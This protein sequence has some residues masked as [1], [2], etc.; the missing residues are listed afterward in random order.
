MEQRNKTYYL[1]L[2]IG[3]DSVGYAA[4]N[5]NYE[6]IKF[7]G[8][9]VWGVTTFE[10][11]M[12][13][14]ERRI[15]R[16]SRRRLD[17]RQQRVQ[18]V[19]EI[20]QREICKIDPLFFIRRKESA[21]FAEDS[22]YGVSLL[23][24]KKADQ[25]YHFRYPT[26]HH[27]I[28]D[29]MTS[30]EPHDV[31][32]VYLAC[33]WLVVNRGHFL[34]NASA[35][36]VGDFREPYQSFLECFTNS[37]DCCTPWPESISADVIQRI[38]Q[39]DVNI[40]RKK[41]MFKAE[42]FGGKSPAKKPDADFPFSRDSIVTLLSGGK[43][44]PK[45][46]F[47]ND[48]YKE[49]DSVSLG[50]E[51]EKF[52]S[53]LGELDEDAE[54]LRAMRAM[55]DCALL[56]ITLRGKSS[57]SE[58]MVA[59][60]D[61]HHNDL[62]FLKYFIRKYQKESYN[63]I[64]RN[65]AEGNYVAYSG[66]VKNCTEANKVKK[67]KKEAFC[68]YIR[69]I[70]SKIT[71]EEADSEKYEDMLQRLSLY[72]FL[73][74]QKNSDNRVIPHQLY[75]YELNELLRHAGAYL[76]M[77]R[78]TDEDGI[79]NEEKI[80]SIFSFRI[81]YYVG[82]LNKQSPNAW[83]ERKSGKIYP[84]NFEKMVDQDASEQ[85]FIKRMTNICTYLPG[86]DVLPYCSMLYNRFMVLNEL[87]CLKVNG[88][89]IPIAVKQEIYHE[90]FEKSVKKATLKSI[91]G[92]LKSR[93][94]ISTAD[95]VSGV[96]VVMKASLKSYHS[97]RRMLESGQLT[98]E[99]VEDII[100]H[101]AYS[102]DKGRMNRWL[103]ANYPS[104]PDAD[105]SYILRL[106]LKEFGRLSRHF[107]T[108]I[109]GARQDGHGEA[110]SIMD[111]L[112]QTNDNLMQLLSE[113]YTFR[114]AVADFTEEYYA[115]PQNKK[116]LSDRLDDLYVSNAVKR[117]II[118]TLDIVS[119][120]VKAMKC[121]PAKIFV[122]MARGGTPD[123]KGKRTVSRKQQLLELYKKVK[124]EDVPRLLRELEAM[125]DMA[126]NRLQGDKLFLYYMQL[127]K[128]MYTGEAIDL[129]QLSSKAYD[130]D[131]IYPQSKVQDDSIL[132]NKVLCLS[133]A[134]GKKSD[135]YPIKADVRS[136]M[137]YFWAYLKENGL[138]T[139]E[140]YHRL[141][142][143]T[144]FTEEELHQFINR[145]LVETRQS[146]K[147][148]AQLLQERY[149]DAE[150]VYVK[151]GMVSQ[152]RQEFNMLKCRAVNDLHHAKDAYLNI[153]V[154]NVY[155]EK[156]TRR[157][158]NVKQDYTLN[159]RPLFTHP[160]ISGGTT[161]W[162][163][164]EDLE[165]VR[166]SV[167]KNAVHLTRYA[168]CRKGGLFK[169][170][171]KAAAGLVPRK[172][173]LPTEKYG[174][175]NK[176]TAS[177]YLLVSYRIGKKKDIMFAP[178]EL[179]EA[180]RVKKDSA[181]ALEYI[182]QVVSEING[183]KKVENAEILLNGRPI[184]INTVLSLDGMRVTLRG[185]SSG[186]SQMIVASNMPLILSYQEEKYIKALGSVLDKLKNN[187]HLQLDAAH[188]GISAENNLALYESLTKKATAS[189]F[190]KCPGNIGHALVSGRELF[191]GLKL[192]EQ[193]QTLVS[194][195]SWFNQAQTCDLSLVGGVK[196]AGAKVPNSRL[197]AYTK[198]Y[199]DIRILDLSASGLFE[200]QSENLLELL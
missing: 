168:F 95:T 157:W 152:F 107:L 121:P 173:G 28:L 184:K 111:A 109:M 79:S 174:G 145:Q 20:F 117:P 19:N 35:D 96:D 164:G 198:N 162:R 146:T 43:A 189:V 14:E 134:N 57:I 197:A 102:E 91:T 172:A 148:V 1:G 59:A 143:S 37:Y 73:P 163:G 179:L 166:K 24:D 93:G 83:L 105:R 80:R 141:T 177:F 142:R 101:A 21:L 155:H 13:A 5:E 129:E 42:V 2:D 89:P 185:K 175:Y 151:A 171:E 180:E 69:G 104:L 150:I 138:I 103:A 53:I 61:Q 132:N 6:P 72:T 128:C 86:E 52:D 120:V 8:E 12:L 110:M 94:Y 99:Q 167:A 137:Q 126:D 113:R 98:E 31:R 135:S 15:N 62:Q 9:P 29:L 50:M 38:M 108:G 195:V 191:A 68:D 119:D 106:N 16:T 11:A 158:F 115:D 131:H 18:L 127:G 64:F 7:R 46:M 66:N 49:L 169:Q 176:P 100:N 144:A 10:A 75:E 188:S 77:L 4:S 54:L 76:P 159:I 97:F 36:R 45:D 26:I 48:D 160:V 112:W 124:G 39:S 114:D 170:P 181:Y 130:I 161:V 85:A 192:L 34:S 125:G 78:E 74:K 71:P 63:K 82:P 118:R 139:E 87:N 196:K 44:A 65:A 156:F 133:S 200:S 165:K 193:V 116:S 194:I 84:W 186:G 33:A 122:E 149:P 30:T 199:S 178:V 187:P 55:Y 40:T 70:V 140:K 32:L 182:T 88:Q 17:R 190:S 183:G 3:T 136:K 58:A 23:G 56:N 154:G 41:A 27:L 51:E 81:P 60:F 47:C 123:Q 67:V 22:R 153:V 90:L 25:A 92:F 147:V